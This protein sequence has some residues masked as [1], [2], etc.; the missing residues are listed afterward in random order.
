MPVFSRSVVCTNHRIGVYISNLPHLNIQD[1]CMVAI[2]DQPVP[3]ETV[4][5]SETDDRVIEINVEKAWE[6][7]GLNL[8]RDD[9]QVKVS[10]QP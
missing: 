2:Q 7:M 8:Q 6:Q 1:D 3:F 10:F 9:V 5:R 4:N